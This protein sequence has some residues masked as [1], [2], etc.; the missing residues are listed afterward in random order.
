M[1]R[2]APL[3]ILIADDHAVVRRGLRTLLQLNRRWKV[4][5]EAGSGSEAIRK[6]MRFKPDL[7]LLDIS[8]PDL[9]GLEAA[10]EIRW[11]S[12]QTKVL[13]LTMH[14]TQDFIQA[15]MKAGAQGYILKSDAETDLITA[16]DELVNGRTFFTKAVD[17]FCTP[18]SL[19][20]SVSP[21]SL[22]PRERQVLRL[23]AEGK[24]N[25]QLAREL[26]ISSRTVENHRARLMSKLDVHSL[27][28]LVRYAIR[29]KILEA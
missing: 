10:V 4:C 12:P 28:E 21:S 22:T 16:V 2:N 15:A 24:T 6:A 29:H 17:T 1:V 23:I 25:K 27:S 11:A 8:M 19:P 14:H 7:V 18:V 9:N 20:G 5:G 26:G 13:M 3:S